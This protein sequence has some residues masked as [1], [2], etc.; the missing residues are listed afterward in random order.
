M[1]ALVL[2]AVLAAVVLPS[3]AGAQSLSLTETEVLARLS[4]SSPRVRAIRA[5][6]DIARVDVLAAGRWPNPQGS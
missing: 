6:I 4:L 1:R 3:T 5:A 2:C